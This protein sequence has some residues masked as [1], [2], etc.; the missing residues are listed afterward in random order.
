MVLDDIEFLIEYLRGNNSASPGNRT[1]NAPPTLDPGYRAAKRPGS[2]SAA[3]R[4]LSNADIDAIVADIRRKAAN[5]AAPPKSAASGTSSA[6]PPR[7]AATRPPIQRPPTARPAP[8][9]GDSQVLREMLAQMK[10]LTE[11]VKQFRVQIENVPRVY[12]DSR[13]AEIPVKAAGAP[14]GG[15]GATD[16]AASPQEGTPPPEEYLSGFVLD[17][18][19]GTFPAASTFDGNGPSGTAET[20]FPTEQPTEAPTAEQ[21]TEAPTA[22]QPQKKPKKGNKAL[23]VI[24]NILFYVV[25]L[26]M[27]LGA[28]FMRSTAS[29]GRPF[30]LAGFSAATVLTGSMEDVY[31]RGSLI[32][33]K[34]VDA[35]ELQVGDD[36]TYM[37][38][39]TSSITHRIIGITENYQGTGERAFETQG[40]MNPTPDRELIA[41]AN[42][43]GKV[44]FHSK[45]LGNMA[46]FVKQNWPF[47]LFFIIVLVGLI[48]FLKWNARKPAGDGEEAGEKA[49]KKVTDRDPKQK[50]RKKRS[51]R[52]KND[53]G[54]KQT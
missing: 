24:S 26:S 11:E 7:P 36:I 32:I 50:K 45:F 14:P 13:P 19:D 35:G 39:E 44:V 4:N 25:I 21:P 46:N 9:G 17:S 3:Q 40:V 29:D 18:Y 43:V 37:V 31:P 33:T 53:H 48:T 38:S 42:V 22:E 10:E 2:S 15:V 49:T 54:S 16:P 23:S 28:F 8:R 41:A 51:E 30:M 12:Q 20:N 1:T 27:V 5:G 47:L 34:S 6:P 52:R